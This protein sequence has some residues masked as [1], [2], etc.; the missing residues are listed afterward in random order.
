MAGASRRGGVVTGARGGAG[1]GDPTPLVPARA[2]GGS[3]E[4]GGWA[5][6]AT[7]VVALTGWLLAGVVP[8]PLGSESSA[9]Q[10][11]NFYSH[12]TRV[13]AGLVI[14]TLGVCLVFPLI[15]V[16]GVHM[17]RMEGRTPILT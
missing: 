4:L 13:L 11:V 5:G 8:I 10:V 9:E 12:D 7:V 6:P 16:I 17:V 14:S 15:A 2:R 1:R 3:H